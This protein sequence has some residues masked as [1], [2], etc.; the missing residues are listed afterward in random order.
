LR[1]SLA[2]NRL[3]ASRVFWLLFGEPKS[4]TI[5]KC[6]L[7]THPATSPVNSLLFPEKMTKNACLW[8]IGTF[9]AYLSML[10]FLINK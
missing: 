2:Q 9:L 4:D 10:N 8:G 3:S 5:R 6:H 7:V 1:L